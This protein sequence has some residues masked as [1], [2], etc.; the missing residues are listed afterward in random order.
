VSASI[1]PHDLV[2]ALVEE[3]LDRQQ[4]GEHP[5]IEEYEAKHPE[6]AEELRELLEAV[7]VVRDLRPG[8]GDATGAL[9]GPASEAPESRPPER[10]GDYRILREIGRGGMGVVYEAEQVSL[11]R[12]VALKVLPMQAFQD[13]ATLERFRREARA[14]AKLHHTNIV[15]VF[16]VGQEG[17]V[18]YYAM[19]FI[20][21]QGLDLVIKELDRL[22]RPHPVGAEASE[23]GEPVAE[24]I[25]PQ[26]A[27]SRD[28]AVVSITQSLLSGRFE[29]L[30]ADSAS[31]PPS[32]STP[33]PST[34]APAQPAVTETDTPS[35][36]F[37]GGAK[38]ST[39]E[40]GRRQQYYRSV[41][42]I[43]QQAAAALAYAHARGVVHRDIK[44]SNL[45]LD[46]V[47]VV[48]VTDFGLAKGENEGLTRTGDVLGT[49]RYMAP[50][51]F[52]GEGDGRA[53][54]YALGLTL[55]ELLTL[56][57]AF[58]SPDRL[59]LIEDVRTREPDR[60]RSVDPWVPRDLETIVL[61]AIDKDPRRRYPTAEALGGD[62]RRFLADEPIQA[63]PV[64]ALGRG[65][66]WCHRNPALAGSLTAVAAALVAVA[67]I[68]ALYATVQVRAARELSDVWHCSTTSMA[69]P[70]ARRGRS[71]RAC[72][73]WSRAGARP[74]PQAPP[75]GSVRP[76][77]TWPPGN[78]S[79]PSSRDYSPTPWRFQL[80]VRSSAPTA[81]PC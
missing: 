54:V 5:R 70:P 57:P 2:E 28:R 18:N 77:P 10:V 80:G 78:V 39:A 40:T 33:L 16:E 29:V 32:G 9:V 7:A 14:A 17:G 12:R 75:T 36:V 71:A 67:V 11:G 41:A 20:P 60:P 34:S 6:L 48:W 45:L 65:W 74:S 55:Y 53:D 62:L 3:F 1:G 27:P 51:R 72:S 23:P 69:R 58:G 44:P 68:S 56:R 19:Q 31:Q 30:P 66:R 64:G 4:R 35:A 42:R 38:L 50:E 61:K 24:G 15:P 52:R 21:G 47:G 22:R 25:G 37:P 46:A 13:G 8:S 59:R 73:G 49:L 43:G 79:A 76:A 26:A 81:G 63:R